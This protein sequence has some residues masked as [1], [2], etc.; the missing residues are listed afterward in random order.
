MTRKRFGTFPHHLT[1]KVIGV[2]LLFMGMTSPVEGADLK[3]TQNSLEINQL[4]IENENN[5]VLNSDVINQTLFAL[6]GAK[7]PNFSP[8]TANLS[9][10][11]NNQPSSSSLQALISTLSQLRLNGNG[12]TNSASADVPILPQTEAADILIGIYAFEATSPPSSTPIDSITFS[13]NYILST[14]SISRGNS[15]L[16]SLPTGGFSG[17]NTLGVAPIR[18]INPQV[19]GIATPRGASSLPGL[20]AASPPNTIN[21]PQRQTSIGRI[22]TAVPKPLA[23]QDFAAS[24]R[25]SLILFLRE[26]DNDI[27]NMFQVLDQFETPTIKTNLRLLPQQILVTPLNLKD[28]VF[29]ATSNLTNYNVDAAPIRQSQIQQTLSNQVSQSQRQQF[30]QQQQRLGNTQESFKK[31]FEKQ[32]QQQEKREAK[33]RERQEKIYQKRIDRQ[34]RLQERLEKQLQKQLEKQEKIR[35]KLLENRKL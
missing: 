15:G 30:Q 2:S 11:E 4:Q 8:I 13:G 1:L 16:N 25:N 19:G 29:T 6:D 17:A 21:L 27:N 34:R 12:S 5:F 3:F 22:R 32:Q 33:L 10:V 26:L 28:D 9:N 20:N 23:S 7:L 31:Q 14:I 18:L 24:P 35:E